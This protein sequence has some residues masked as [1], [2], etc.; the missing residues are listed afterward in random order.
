MSTPHRTRPGH[1]RAVEAVDRR[2]AVAAAA[3]HAASQAEVV[4]GDFTTYFTALADASAE[5]ADAFDEAL[6]VLAP[7]T[8]TATYWAY[9][10]ACTTAR[11]RADWARE[12]VRQRGGRQ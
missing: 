3:V 7:R 4:A 5:L 2:V 8:D 9:I 6:A 11:H 10:R 12:Q 1:A